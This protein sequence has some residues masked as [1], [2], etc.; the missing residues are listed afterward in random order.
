M[1]IPFLILILFDPSFCVISTDDVIDDVTDVTL[2][3]V[4]ETVTTFGQNRLEKCPERCVC[5]PVVVNCMFL[6]IT[7]MTYVL[8]TI[9][10][11]VEMM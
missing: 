6:N 11:S 10:Q 8:R 9:P 4:P 5:S 3:N 7:D 2:F 1:L